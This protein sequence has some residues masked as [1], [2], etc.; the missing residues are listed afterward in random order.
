[1][2]PK[3]AQDRPKTGPR[4]SWIV[5]LPLNFSLR[6]W[7]VFGSVLVSFWVP[8]WRPGGDIKMPLGG[9]GALLGPFWCF[10]GPIFCSPW[11]FW[12]PWML[13]CCTMINITSSFLLPSLFL[14]FPLLPFPLPRRFQLS[15][16]NHLFYGA[17]LLIPSLFLFPLG[18][19]I[20][21]IRS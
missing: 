1:M 14:L 8:K 9:P 19:S 2:A 17:C 13:A 10:F 18:F 20:I 5:F 21:V 11:S 12:R 4:S 15:L 6:F 3:T 16:S 7:I